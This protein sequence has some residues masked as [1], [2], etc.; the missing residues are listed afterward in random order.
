MMKIL[1]GCCGLPIGLEKYLKEFKILEINNTFYK[2]PQLKTAQKWRN[3]VPK[4]FQFS[5]KVFQAITHPITSPTWKRSGIKDLKKLKDKVGYL[6]PRKEVFDFWN[7]TL[8][9]CNILQAKICLIQLPASFKDHEENLRNANKFFSKIKRN[10]ISIAIELRGWKE[11]NI[12]DLCKKFDIIDCCDPF[13]RLP[14]YLGKNKIAYFRLHG[15]PPGKKMYNYKYTK[16]NLLKLKEIVQE[17]KAK[18]HY[19]LFNNLSMFEDAKDFIK[20]LSS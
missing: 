19:I 13:K 10:N 8:E 7:K 11:K 3:I 20:I 2:L 6:R 14:T 15:S 5:V 1:V 16:E 9:I 18:D 17:V 4:D 12:L